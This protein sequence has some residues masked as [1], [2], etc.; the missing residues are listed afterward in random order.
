VAAEPPPYELV[1]AGPAARAIADV[2]PE[3]VAVAVITLITGE[4]LQAPRRVGKP[5]RREL[6]GNWVARRGTFRVVYRIDE[7]HHEVVVLR[8]DHRRDIYRPH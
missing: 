2:L 1:V 7:D 5:L 4:L 3:Q 8:V 6:E